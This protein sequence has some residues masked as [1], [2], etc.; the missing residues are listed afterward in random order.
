MKVRVRYMSSIQQA[1]RRIPGEAVDS[2]FRL[3][4]ASWID[5]VMVYRAVCELPVEGHSALRREVIEKFFSIGPIKDQSE[6]IV[7]RPPPL[8]NLPGHDL[9]KYALQASGIE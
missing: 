5:C 6:W 3:R 1:H 8:G 4:Q 7:L 9:A 2:T